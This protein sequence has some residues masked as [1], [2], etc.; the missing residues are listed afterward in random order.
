MGESKDRALEA[1]MDWLL[2]IEAAPGDAMLRSQLEAWRS[3]DPAH[4]RAWTRAQ[5]AWSVVGDSRPAYAAEWPVRPTGRSRSGSV[6]ARHGTAWRWGVAASLAIAA[7]L[8]L[9]FMPT[10]VTSLRADHATVTA[11]LRDISLE[12]GSRVHL[13]PRS[14]L[15]V[16]FAPDRRTVTLLDGGAF[17]EVVSD[18][19]RPFVV[20][21]GGIDVVVAG[22]AFDVRLSKEL[23]VVEVRSGIVDLRGGAVGLASPARLAAGDRA[24]VER[25]TGNIRLDKVSPDEIAAWRDRRLFVE[26]ASVADVVEELSRYRS[27]WIVLADSRLAAQRVT[28]LFDLTDT[29]HAL[30]AI[31]QPFNGRVHSVTPY[32]QILSAP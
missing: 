14:A 32:L 5:K 3:A 16:R 9:L 8:F 10:I 6:G 22:T 12:D 24:R 30:T 27:G 18:P 31:V 15:D 28:G 2:R 11:E 19:R 4:A 13:G 23:I 7:G 1:A 25:A 29:D 21:A 26:G 17:F 20:S